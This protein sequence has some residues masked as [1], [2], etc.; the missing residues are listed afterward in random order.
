[1][2]MI[3]SV[4]NWFLQE[5]KKKKDHIRQNNKAR[6]LIENIK[7]V[8]GYINPGEN[9]AQSTKFVLSYHITNAKVCFA[10]DQARISCKCSLDS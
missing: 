1:M 2:I 4:V 8:I 3:S 6:N 5:I 7:L 10:H 9:T